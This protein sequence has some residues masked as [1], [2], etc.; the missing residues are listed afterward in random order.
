[1]KKTL[2]V[3]CLM[4]AVAGCGKISKHGGS[5]LT[6]GGCQYAIYNGT[7]GVAMTHAGDCPNLIHKR[8]TSANQQ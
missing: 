6:I 3:L 4:I 1:M 7:K 8:T 2:T 5:L